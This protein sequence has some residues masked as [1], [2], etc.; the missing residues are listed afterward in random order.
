MT[1]LAPNIMSV[2]DYLEFEKT[3][4]V[5]HEYVDG[6]LLE[7]PGVSRQHSRI[8][9]NIVKALDD[10][11]LAKGCELHPTEVMTRTHR[12]RFRY[13]D[14]VVTCAPGDHTHILENPCFLV[15]VTSDSTSDTDHGPKLEEYTRLPSMQ[16]Y[17]IVSQTRVRSS[18]TNEKRIAGHSRCSSRRARLTSP[19][20]T[21]H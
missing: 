1:M 20:W 11:A 19:A 4:E 7:M 10:I 2:E 16:C 5:R 3:A 14:I 18:S 13:P 17:A 8:V 15:E 12:T 21:R 9:I 6:I